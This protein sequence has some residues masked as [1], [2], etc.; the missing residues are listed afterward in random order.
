MQLTKKWTVAGL[1]LLVSGF[2]LHPE[3]C[4]SSKELLTQILPNGWT[5]DG[6]THAGIIIGSILAIL[7]KGLFQKNEA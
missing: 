2:F 4:V 6:V 7:G 3:S 5:E 1:V